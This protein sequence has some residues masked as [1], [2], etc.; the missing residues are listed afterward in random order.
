MHLIL[1][2]RSSWL[3]SKV[4]AF[5]DVNVY[6]DA[7]SP[8]WDN[9]LNG[10]MNLHDALRGKIEYDDNISGKHYELGPKPAVLLVRYWY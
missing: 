5:F 10:Q 2:P 1:E 6:I 7:M 9:I 8:T 4:R 3:I